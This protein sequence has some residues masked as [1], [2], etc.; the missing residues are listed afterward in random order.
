[1][2]SEV[3]APVLAWGTSEAFEHGYDDGKEGKRRNPYACLN[4]KPVDGARQEQLTAWHNGNLAGYL[5]RSPRVRGLTHSE[6]MDL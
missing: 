1:M 5:D 3:I 6:A 2:N 4:G